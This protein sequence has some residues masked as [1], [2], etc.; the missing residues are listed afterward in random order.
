MKKNW[1]RFVVLILCFLPPN[2][3]SMKCLSDRP[4]TGSARPYWLTASRQQEMEKR[5]ETVLNANDELIQRTLQANGGNYFRQG[6]SKMLIFRE[7]VYD[8]FSIDVLN[9]E[10]IIIKTID[11]TFR[12]KTVNP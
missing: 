8:D 12:L 10:Y 11:G 9:G 1:I 2:V 5:G 3:F 4:A 6:S 7:K